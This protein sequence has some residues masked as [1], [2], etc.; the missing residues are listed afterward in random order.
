M[1]PSCNPS[2]EDAQ[3]GRSLG[4]GRLDRQASK[5]SERHLKMRNEIVSQKTKWGG[6][7]E[8]NEGCTLPCT[9]TC[10]NTETATVSHRQTIGRI[11]W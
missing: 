2:A 6:T 4:L 5:T 8:D 9:W 11:V 10:E 7:V 1:V 3:I